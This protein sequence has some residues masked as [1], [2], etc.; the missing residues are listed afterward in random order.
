MRTAEARHK[1]Y[2][3]VEQCLGHRIRGV[4]GTYDRHK[5]QRQMQDAYE[6]LAR[7][8]DVIINPQENVISLRPELSA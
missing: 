5:Y 1:A 3:H 7:Q 6:R 4:Q 2:R 8:I